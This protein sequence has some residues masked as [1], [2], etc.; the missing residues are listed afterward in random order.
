MRA[1]RSLLPL[2]HFSNIDLTHI[3][4]PFI[5]VRIRHEQAITVKGCAETGYPL[6][7]GQF[8]LHL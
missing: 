6:R 7:Y 2:S 4:S 1:A 3:V 8:L 5:F